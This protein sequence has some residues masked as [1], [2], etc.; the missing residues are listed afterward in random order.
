[1][2]RFGMASNARG[3]CSRI[4]SDVTDLLSHHPKIKS[5]GPGKPPGN[6]KPLLH[7]CTVLT[8]TAWEVYVEDLLLEAVPYFQKPAELPKML[9]EKVGKRVQAKP[10]NLAETGWVNEVE[11]AVRSIS[12]GAPGPGEWGM[13]TANTKNVNNAFETVFGSQLLNRCGWQGQSSKGNRDYIDQLVERRGALVHR[14]A[15]DSG[16]K[17]LSL[18][19]VRDWANWVGKLADKVDDLSANALIGLTGRL[20]W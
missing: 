9:R 14:G 8:Y 12:V 15:L 18:G 16:D 6:T 5:P 4:L 11:K 1:M 10:W 7:A 3:S 20:A 19:R 13:N 2:Q 17:P